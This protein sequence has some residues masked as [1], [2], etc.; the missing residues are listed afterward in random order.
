MT[1]RPGQLEWEDRQR[2]ENLKEQYRAIQ[3]QVEQTLERLEEMTNTLNEQ[4]L[5]SPETLEKFTELQSLMEQMNSPEFQDAMRKLQ[6]AM[7]RLDPEQVR[8]AMEQ[9]SL[10]DENVRRS[11][12]RT[13]SLLKRIQIEQKLDALV[14]QSERMVQQQ[15]DLQETAAERSGA[16]PPD[17]EDLLARQEALGQ[18]LEQ[19]QDH[20]AELQQ[21][22]EEFPGEMP[23]E[24]LRSV[25]DSIAQSGLTE[26]LE[27]IE[28]ALRSGT[29]ANAREHQRQASGQ[30]QAMR[31]QMA[32][33]R[34][35]LRANQQR[36]VANEMRRALE[37]LL[38]LSQR[39]ERLG[40]QLE[41]LER[42]TGAEREMAQQQMEIGRDLSGLTQ[43]LSA[44]SQKTFGI[45]PEMGKAIG[46]AQRAM[47]DA[48]GS[49]ERRD[50]RSAGGQQQQAMGSLNEAA[51]MMQWSLQALMQGGQGMGMAGFMQRLEQLAGQ[52]QGINDAT[53]SMGGMTQQQAAA[54][55]RLAG[56][57][58]AARR[59][60]EELAR[61]AA[62][63]GELSKL[64]G[65]LTRIAQE[66][67]EV[68]TD[69]L[70]GEVNPET[71]QKQDRILS[72]LLDSQRS[73]RERD[74]ERRRRAER[75][76]T[77]L[78][79][80]PPE[81]ETA[82]RDGRDRLRQDLLKA[83]EEGYARDYQALIRKYF[84]VLDHEQ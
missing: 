78:R 58:A 1:A 40:R 83:L 57:Q 33:V 21:Q 10:S 30:M 7:Q 66:M 59:S 13:I 11:L 67:R 31:D 72:R 73:M 28:Q 46:D 42:G 26:E 55:S 82:N 81:L 25:R 50:A 62:G 20:L 5:L 27:A 39:Q 6:E 22:M 69:L 61:E 51:Q 74:F 77:P 53:R 29:M 47:G 71:L 32:A 75:G 17:A 43:R 4:Q 54:L 16:N 65:D 38:E 52:Q 12:E 64:L 68:Q 63:A 24:E 8:R 15:R 79:D 36:H 9:L 41:G 44:L 23:R 70:Q 3:Q 34:D 19:L 18:Q 49:L 37:D 60:L 2:A 56:E 84:E 48:I 14:R 35:A 80:S 76:T 45:T